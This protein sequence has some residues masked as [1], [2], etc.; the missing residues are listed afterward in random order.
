M[1][2]HPKYVDY[3]ILVEEASREV[4]LP[5]EAST[6]LFRRWPRLRPWPDVPPFMARVT[7]PF[8]VVTNCSGSLAV[9]AATRLPRRPV[10]VISAEMAGAYKPDPRP[11]AAALAVLQ[12]RVEDVLY[13]AGSAYDARGAHA[14]GL[15]TR[16]ID[17]GSA[18]EVVPVIRYPSLLRLEAELCHGPLTPS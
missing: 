17:R 13:V 14:F 10:A 11:Y 16:W 7:I 18:P 15:P 9:D 3:R 4:G 6:R 2:S 1:I 12:L 8:A 5:A